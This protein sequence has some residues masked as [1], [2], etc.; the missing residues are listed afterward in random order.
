MPAGAVA[1]LGAAA[2]RRGLQV[3]VDT[4][5]PA[6][7][8]AW[9]SAPDLVRINDEELAGALP[10][11]ASSSAPS[12]E[13]PVAGVVSRGARPFDAWDGESRW[14]VSPPNVEAVNAIGC[15]DAMMAGLLASLV[16]GASF[17]SAL[18]TATALASAC[19]EASRAGIVAVAR[20]HDLEAGVEIEAL[21]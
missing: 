12:R 4:S 1:S 17:P 13:T 10:A 5:G 16:R 18:R 15:G 21:A 7:A 2:R 11:Q 3:A 8:E 14:R 9:S 20:A 19:A 6:L